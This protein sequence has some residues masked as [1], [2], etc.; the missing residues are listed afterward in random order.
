MERYRGREDMFRL[1]LLSFETES[2]KTN[3]N[4]FCL[5]F[6]PQNDNN[7]ITMAM[8]ILIISWYVRTE[9]YKDDD[10]EA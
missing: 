9:Q 2:W 5:E 3:R 4:I 8:I 1:L 10:D 7:N 6:G